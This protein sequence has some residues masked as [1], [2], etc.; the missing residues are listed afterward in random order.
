MITIHGINE[1]VRKY[2]LEIPK[3]YWKDIEE[4]IEKKEKIVE[5]FG[6][7]YQKFQLAYAKG[8]LFMLKNGGNGNE[9]Q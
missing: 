2:G 1:L 4:Y 9:K 3:E 6:E 5:K 8:L 7:N